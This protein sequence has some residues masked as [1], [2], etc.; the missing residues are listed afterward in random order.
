VLDLIRQFIHEV[1]EEDEKGRK[2]GT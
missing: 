2:T 1:E